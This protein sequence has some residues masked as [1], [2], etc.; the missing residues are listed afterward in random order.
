[1]R[2][3]RFDECTGAATRIREGVRTREQMAALAAAKV[4]SR[5]LRTIR[6]DLFFHYAIMAECVVKRMVP[7]VSLRRLRN[8]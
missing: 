1:M 2:V 8:T 5:S 7:N 3:N 6:V 4:I